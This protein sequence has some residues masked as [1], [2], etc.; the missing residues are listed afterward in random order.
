[1]EGITH[2]M[3]LSIEPSKGFPLRDLRYLSSSGMLA[4]T[5]AMVGS[6]RY[7]WRLAISFLLVRDVP[8]RVSGLDVWLEPHTTGR[9]QML[10]ERSPNCVCQIT[11]FRLCF[12]MPLR[13][14]LSWRIVRRVARRIVS[15]LGALISEV[16][17]RKAHPTKA[18]RNGPRR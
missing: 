11:A 12:A 4:F 10:I 1:M 18:P 3:R 8:V 9:N 7:C 2:E 15:Q 5:A 16:N 6:G 14:W 13:T 17:L